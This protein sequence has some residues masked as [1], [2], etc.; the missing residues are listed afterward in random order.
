[1]HAVVAA[2]LLTCWQV[3]HRGE[4]VWRVSLPESS[5]SPVRIRLVA[6]AGA[7]NRVIPP[8]NE[9]FSSVSVVWSGAARDRTRTE[10]ALVGKVGRAEVGDGII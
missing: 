3:T 5:V 6:G 7:R 1:M 4:G 2:G 8:G 9:L 10:E